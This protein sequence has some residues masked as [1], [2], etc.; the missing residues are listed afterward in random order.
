MMQGDVMRSGGFQ[1]LPHLLGVGVCDPAEEERSGGVVHKL[2]GQRSGIQRQAT[3]PATVVAGSAGVLEVASYEAGLGGLGGVEGLVG[4]GGVPPG[5]GGWG[6]G[7]GGGVYLGEMIHFPQPATELLGLIQVGCV[8]SWRG[9]AAIP[10]SSAA[11]AP[12]NVEATA[13]T[14]LVHRFRAAGTEGQ[15]QASTQALLGKTNKQ[16]KNTFVH[17]QHLF[18]LSGKNSIFPFKC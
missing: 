2:L 1:A 18:P 9:G 6:G 8:R 13:S 17:N 10:A 12:S 11:A 3:A 4:A 14:L 16:T 15:L 5:G 7:G